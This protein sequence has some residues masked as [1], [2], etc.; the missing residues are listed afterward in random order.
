LID[1]LAR[2]ERAVAYYFKRIC[3]GL[4]RS[5]L[6][7]VAPAADMLSAIALIAASSALPDTS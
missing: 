1:A 3:K 2:P 4:H 5:R 6:T 7:P